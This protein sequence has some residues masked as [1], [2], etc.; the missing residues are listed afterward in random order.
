MHRALVAAPF[1]ST[2]LIIRIGSVVLLI[3]WLL[4]WA[5]AFAVM[6]LCWLAGFSTRDAK[7]A[8]KARVLRHWH[9]LAVLLVM[10][11]GTTISLRSKEHRVY[12]KWI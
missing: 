9:L 2:L 11:G 6:P 3:P 5:I 4:V 7:H 10:M 8:G 12:L 1:P